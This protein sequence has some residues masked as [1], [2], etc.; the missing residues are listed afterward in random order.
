M[1]SEKIIKIWR[2]VYMKLFDESGYVVLNKEE[3]FCDKKGH[4]E[5][6]KIFWRFYF[7]TKQSKYGMVNR[8]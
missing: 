7:I 3:N 6:K 1:D 2:L 5:C 4:Y 8:I